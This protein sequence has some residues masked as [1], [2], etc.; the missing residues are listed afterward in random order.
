MQMPIKSLLLFW[1]GRMC[2]IRGKTRFGTLGL[3]YSK[4]LKAS[5][6]AARPSVIIKA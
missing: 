1:T 5:P 4:A 6:F 2:G 3:C